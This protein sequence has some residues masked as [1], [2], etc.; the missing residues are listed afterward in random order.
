LSLFFFVFKVALNIEG[1][2]DIILCVDI[3]MK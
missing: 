2:I 3:Y 1:S